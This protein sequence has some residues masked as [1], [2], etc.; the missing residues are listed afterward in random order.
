MQTAIIVQT[1]MWQIESHGNGFAYAFY[2]KAD[3]REAFL[4]GDDATQWREEFEAMQAA[5]CNPESAWHKQSWNTCLS[6]L[7]AEYVELSQ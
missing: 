5:Y 6:Q 1:D 2:R 3:M 4:Q 7:C